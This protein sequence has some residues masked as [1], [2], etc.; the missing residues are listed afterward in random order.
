MLSAGHMTVIRFVSAQT[1]LTVQRIWYLHIHILE[2]GENLRNECYPGR[3]R[4]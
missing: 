2:Y 3:G 1:F 4:G